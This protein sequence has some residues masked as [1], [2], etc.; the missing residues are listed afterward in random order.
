MTCTL[1]VYNVCITLSVQLSSFLCPIGKKNK[2]L[3]ALT[4]CGVY[5]HFE[6]N[7]EKNTFFQ[8]IFR[9]D[10]EEMGKK[11]Q[12]AGNREMKWCSY[13]KSLIDHTKH[14]L[15]D[16]QGKVYRKLHSLSRCSAANAAMQSN[17]KDDIFH[18]FFSTPILSAFWYSV[19]LTSV[20]WAED[21]TINMKH[22][23][24]TRPTY[25]AISKAHWFKGHEQWPKKHIYLPDKSIWLKK[26]HF[27][28]SELQTDWSL[29]LLLNVFF[30]L[31]L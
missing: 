25:S 8:I 21:L 11:Q 24:H 13:L 7:K 18:C 26:W 10:H 27:I 22:L 16:A 28:F 5:V 15:K 29:P 6:R 2:P 23:D 14:D 30:I 17:K 9:L 3:Y 12:E 19:R 20:S 1:M 4:V 31:N